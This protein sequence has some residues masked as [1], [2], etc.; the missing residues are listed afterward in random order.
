M[1][2]PVP[3]TTFSV[4]VGGLSKAGAYLLILILNLSNHNLTKSKWVWV[5]V[6][7]E[8]PLVETATKTPK[9]LKHYSQL[10]VKE[11]ET[12]IKLCSQAQNSVSMALL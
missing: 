7:V 9:P 11:F 4:Q 8:S 2:L 5:G 1:V 12:E 10:G 3:R 6:G